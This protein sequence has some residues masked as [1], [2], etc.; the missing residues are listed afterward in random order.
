MNDENA[1]LDREKNISYNV[2][3]LKN[4][5]KREVAELIIFFA[6]S[7]APLRTLRPILR[8]HQGTQRFRKERREQS[9]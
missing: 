9:K 4:G 6:F 2:T 8:A 1:Q 5:I 7:A 3:L